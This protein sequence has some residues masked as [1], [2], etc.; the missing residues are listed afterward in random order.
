M[1]R[2]NRALQFIRD[3]HYLKDSVI[4]FSGNGFKML[5][6]F[7]SNLL[8]AKFFGP[9]NLAIYGT[10]MTMLLVMSN[11]SDFG[12]G[13]TLNRLTNRYPDIRK[14]ILTTIFLL[15]ILLLL[16]FLGLFYFFID[17]IAANQKT[18]E[19]RQD[20]LRL[21]I[22]LIAAESL[23]KFLLA[24]HQAG[25]Y[26]KRFSLLLIMNNSFRLAGIVVLFLLKKLTISSII[27]LYTASYL[28]LIVT[29]CRVWRFAFQKIFKII[30][31][32]TRYAFWVW[33]FIIFNT[34]FV[35]S[36]IL[37]INY[38]KYDKHVIGNYTLMLYMVSLI[39]LLQMAIFTQLLPK[40]S[41]F[42]HRADYD[43]YYGEIKYIRIGIVLLSFVYI[44]ILP[45]LLKLL[46]SNQ[47][48]IRPV[49][50]IIFG[51]PFL[52]S[53][54]NEFNSVLLYSMEKHRYISLANALG[55]ACVIIALL[56]YRDVKTSVHIVAAV[57]MG[58]FVVDTFIYLKVKQCLRLVTN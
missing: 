41:Q 4:L 16:I 18:L 42:S 30:P 19:G 24:S 35:R 45:F 58:K 27:V 12:Y 40:T 43:R 48:T 20:L 44:L 47:Y 26:F 34:L 29:H 2:L 33:L 50:I 23:F 7:S 22:L 36:D 32:V 6:G 39:G 51:L 53:L 8:L 56:L 31:Q 55:L 21:L 57:M 10:V 38:L 1:E 3:N 14:E 28:L 5:I 9:E 13:N 37:L 49:L 17:A 46:Y 54:F 52:F 25:H 15:K 11:I